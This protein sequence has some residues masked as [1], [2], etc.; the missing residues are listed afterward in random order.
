MHG[1]PTDKN[2][3][4]VFTGVSRGEIMIFFGKNKV[5]GVE[6]NRVL[7]I[8]EEIKKTKHD[9]KRAGVKLE[10]QWTE[11]VSLTFHS[12]L[13][14][15]NTEPSLVLPTKFRFIWLSSFREEDF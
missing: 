11:T 7:N 15:L 12:A 13:R 3:R 2:D 14:K 4:C 10:A 8:L 5:L 6:A 1:F 9:L